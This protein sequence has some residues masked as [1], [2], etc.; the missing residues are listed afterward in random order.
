MHG[1]HTV[2]ALTHAVSVCTCVAHILINY[3]GAR[4][5][6]FTSIYL[7]EH[8]HLYCGRIDAETDAGKSA[9]NS[10]CMSSSI[11]QHVKTCDG[12]SGWMVRGP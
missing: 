10:R 6:A 12:I 2:I 4:M 8:K 3:I 5:Y 7:Y 11:K 9:I 1:T